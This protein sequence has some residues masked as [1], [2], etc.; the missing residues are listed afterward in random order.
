[1]PV[2][3]DNIPRQEELSAWPYLNSVE[4][5]VIDADVEFLIGT[6]VPKV[7]EPWEVV[8]S[9]GEGPYAIRTLL[10]WVINGPLREGSE[11][12]S[13]CHTVTTNRIS[14]AHLEE[15]LVKQYNHNFNEKTTDEKPEMSRED[16]KFMEIMNSSA[17]F[18]NGRYC[19]RLPFRD[20]NV[21]IPNNHHVGEQRVFC[22]E[23]KLE[24]NATF[25]CYIHVSKNK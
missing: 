15:L 5:P 25:K 24:K 21:A 18:D 10:G 4:I 1:M 22:L 19:L 16:L 6:N 20:A 13:S 14:I 7:M 3:C 12:E 9:N 17:E 23:R 11:T 2:T 8:N